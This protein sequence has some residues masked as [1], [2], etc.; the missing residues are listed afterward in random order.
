MIKRPLS[1]D[2]IPLVLTL[3][4]LAVILDVGLNATRDLVQSGQIKSTRIGTHTRILKP[5]LQRFLLDETGTNTAWTGSRPAIRLDGD[6]CWTA[7]G[8]INHASR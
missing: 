1:F 3:D 7:E 8:G 6:S 5:D 2:D 4:E